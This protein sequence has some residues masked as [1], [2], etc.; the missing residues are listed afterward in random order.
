MC[1]TR[2]VWNLLR[3]HYKTLI[4]LISKH[5]MPIGLPADLHH[6]GNTELAGGNVMRIYE[7]GLPLGA[8]GKLMWKIILSLCLEIVR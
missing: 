5:A 4:A 1:R 7:V 6:V 8:V 3:V 2:E